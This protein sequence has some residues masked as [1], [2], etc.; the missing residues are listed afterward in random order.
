P[1]D[2]GVPLVY[3]PMSMASY[4]ID[5]AFW[6][7]EPAGYHA[8]NVG[9]HV[10]SALMVTLVAARWFPASRWA[11]VVAGALF[12]VHPTFVNVVPFIS[13]RQDLLATVFALIALLLALQR[14]EGTVGNRRLT[15]GGSSAG[16]YLAA[17]L[18]KET[19]VV[20][21]APLS[22]VAWHQTKVSSGSGR[23]VLAAAQALCWHLGFTL[24]WF[25]TRWFVLDGL[26]GYSHAPV[27]GWAGG[28][29]QAALAVSARYTGHLLWPAAI[30]RDAF[31]W[32]LTAFLVGLSL[33]AGCT[34]LSVGAS[35]QARRWFADWVRSPAVNGCLAWIA[36][37]GALLVGTMTFAPRTS[38][39]FTVPA[40]LLVGDLASRCLDHAGPPSGARKGSLWSSRIPTMVF[41]SILLASS[42]ALTWTAHPSLASRAKYND[43][44]LEAV[45]PLVAEQAPDG[46]VTVLNYAPPHVGPH[47]LSILEN[48]GRL[49]GYSIQAWVR[50]T[51]VGHPVVAVT[52]VDG[53]PLDR[54]PRE[55]MVSPTSGPDV[56]TL[57]IQAAQET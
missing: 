3:R 20:L 53:T 23:R 44:V 8:T 18:S 26:G 33:L 43:A 34:V 17:L 38:Y 16:F 46:T 31:A 11:P 50:A 9:L 22:L 40:V 25:V 19:A 28:Y 55:V 49:E 2:A 35:G 30:L 51:A 1:R 13:R 15:A 36:A 39:L 42:V 7:M 29:P 14:L 12:A 4:V 54:L 21:L 24:L 5:H 57:R 52:L 6:G 32:S 56:T 47:P 27:L 45:T 37:G 48:E 10:L 41:L